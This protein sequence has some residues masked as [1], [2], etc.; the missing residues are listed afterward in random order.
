MLPH[1]LGHLPQQKERQFP[2]FGMSIPR[3]CGDESE[4][5]G[6]TGC[7]QSRVGIRLRFDLANRGNE[8][9]GSVADGSGGFGGEDGEEL[10]FEGGFGWGVESFEVA[11]YA[12][13]E[14]Y[15]GY[16]ADSFVLQWGESGDAEM[17]RLY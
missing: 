16:V 13:A 3:G 9:H 14:D 17:D 2:G 10:G 7:P 1:R 15:G 4:Q 6:P 8:C 5:L 11:G 12:F